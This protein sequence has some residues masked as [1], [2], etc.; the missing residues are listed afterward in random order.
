MGTTYWEQWLVIGSAE[1]QHSIFSA[2]LCAYLLKDHA[3]GWIV[4]GTGSTRGA[5]VSC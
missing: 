3:L 2:V 1:Q 5:I 4:A